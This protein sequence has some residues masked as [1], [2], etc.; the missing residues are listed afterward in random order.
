MAQIKVSQI[1]KDFNIKSKDVIDVFK[2]L[3]IE[4][5][6]GASVESEEYELFL[7]NLTATHQ[8]GN[9]DDYID[10]KTKITVISEKKEEKPQEAPKAEEKVAEAPKAEP[11]KAPVAKPAE[12][13]VEKAPVK[14]ER[15]E[16]TPDKRVDR[17]Q[18]PR[19][20]QPQGRDGAKGGKDYKGSSH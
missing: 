12:K 10:G 19:P 4:K 18:N 5:K 8:I 17:P 16:S 13:P 6:S 1:S 11:V 15:K 2:A 7:H 3:G 20:T 9:I 14:E